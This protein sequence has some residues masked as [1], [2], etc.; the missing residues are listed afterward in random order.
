ME[1]PRGFV[2]LASL[3]IFGSWVLCIGL[4]PPANPSLASY[5]PG[6]RLMVAC[7][8]VGV[9]AGWPL[10]RLSGPRERWPVRRV[11]ID[12]L[13]LA[14]IVHVVLW[15]LRLTTSWPPSRLAVMDATIFAWAVITGAIIAVAIHTNDRRSRTLAMIMCVLITALG[16]PLLVGAASLGLA[17]PPAWLQGPVMN[18]LILGAEGGAAPTAG[19]W[20]GVAAICIGGIVSWT[21]AWWWLRLPS[22]ELPVQH[23]TDKLSGIGPPWN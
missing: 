9:S 21:T 10:L 16:L 12:Y 19:G 5:S 7:L 14:A 11:V 6:V 1:L 13:T 18:T 8:A 22:A 20:A 4:Q 3:W 15:P 17:P 23:S 2:V